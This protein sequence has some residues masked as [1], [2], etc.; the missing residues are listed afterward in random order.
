M[1]PDRSWPA[2]SA[3]PCPVEVVGHGGAGGLHPGN[4]QAAM[5]AA[6]AI[7]V[8][9]IECDVRRAA[10]GGLVLVHDDG[11]SLDNGDRRLVRRLT[12]RELRGALPGLLT[13]DELVELVSGRAPLMIDVKRSGYEGEVVAA[14][15]RHRL[16]DASSLSCTYVSTLRR[17][18]AA[19]PSMRLGLSTGHWAGG[20]PTA[21]GRVAARWLLRIGAPVPLVAALRLAGASEAMLQHRIVTAPLVATLHAGGWRVNVWTVDR[22]ED[23]RRALALGVDG[24]ISNRP[25]LVR[26]ALEGRRPDRSGQ[27]SEGPA[28]V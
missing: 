2:R 10:D 8:D 11:V 17:V 25:D 27:A 21:P 7:G 16:D 20:T 4:G 13:F 22:P 6:L 19:Y 15:R 28:S 3:A 24:V 18:R 14:I 26:M 5:V 23:I 1:I 9:R 12:T